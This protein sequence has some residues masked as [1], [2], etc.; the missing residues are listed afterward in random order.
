M[1]RLIKAFLPCFFAFFALSALLAQE[2]EG[3][4]TVYVEVLFIEANTQFSLVEWEKMNWKPIY[5]ELMKSDF[6][7]GWQLFSVADQS[8][9]Y[10]QYNYAVVHYY[11]SLEQ[12][13]LTKG[14][15]ERAFTQAHPD[16]SMDD[17]LEKSKKLREILYREVFKLEHRL[18]PLTGLEGGEYLFLQMKR[19][20]AR[21]QKAFIDSEKKQS[22]NLL[23]SPDPIEGFENRSLWKVVKTEL[24]SWDYN[25]VIIERWNDQALMQD[26]ERA[27]SFDTDNK[28]KGKKKAAW[29]NIKSEVWVLEDQLL[30]L[31]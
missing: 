12:L 19:V 24:A 4:S 1:A 27:E 11:N 13:E 6:S 28:K 9:T 30:E 3:P 29:K 31:N 18:S 14:A 25:F 7:S 20:P 2:Q 17:I 22:T 16:K 21:K 15:F 26:F 8:E 10:I 5:A 23:E